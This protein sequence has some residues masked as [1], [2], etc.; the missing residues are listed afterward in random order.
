MSPGS[1]ATS[2]TGKTCTSGDTQGVINGQSKCLAAGQQCSSKAIS[3]YP[4]YG[5]V[6]EN[7]NGKYVLRRK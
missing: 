7:S 2:S 4:Q 5:F 3:S 6:C 1:S